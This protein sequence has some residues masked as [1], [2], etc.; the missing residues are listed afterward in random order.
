M[1]KPHNSARNKRVRVSDPA[2]RAYKA[3][4]ASKP[5]VLLSFD[6]FIDQEMRESW[7]E[8]SLFDLVRYSK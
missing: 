2:R 5:S 8:R 1:P 3:Y 6:E 4:V 7:H